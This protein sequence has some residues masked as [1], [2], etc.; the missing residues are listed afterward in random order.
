M[1][2]DLYTILG[3]SPSCTL[4]EI[5]NQFK[6]LSRKYHPDKRPDSGDFYK[7]I[8]LAHSILTDPV[9]REE[10]D[11]IRTGKSQELDYKGLKEESKKPISIDL[12]A[13]AA[14]HE[15]EV[16]QRHS[17]LI[18]EYRERTIGS[19]KKD[20]SLSF[21]PQKGDIRRPVK[22]GKHC[23][24]I[25]RPDVPL[26]MIAV[27][28]KYQVLEK[29]GEMYY[30]GEQDPSLVEYASDVTQEEWE[31]R[32]LMVQRLPPLQQRIQERK[33]ECF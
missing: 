32:H 20:R 13:L 30:R 6:C 1:S 15:T 27:P 11:S 12:K 29:L 22:S 4:K 31:E 3:V 7:A 23:S 33:S 21:A 14:Q 5:R 16:A 19:V 2:D 28:E 18:H 17:T 8:V 25:P 26:A 9:L 10:Y 24:V